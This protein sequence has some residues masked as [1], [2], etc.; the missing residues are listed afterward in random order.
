MRSI[1]MARSPPRV[2]KFGDF[3][4]STDPN[5]SHVYQCDGNYTASVEV[6]DDRGAV[7]SATVPVTVSSAGGP[8]T[9]A[10]DV[11]PVFNRVCTGCHGAARGLSLT[12]CENLQLGSNPRP[13][14]VVTP[15]VKEAS[16]LWQ[17]INS[18]TQP[19][20]PIGGLLPAAEIAA[21]GAWIDSL[22]PLDTNY[23]D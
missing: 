5:A 21:I 3:T 22:D 13:R 18:T 1:P 9:H 10:C 2:W 4:S 20:P 23:C 8:V 16:I 19:M 17:R 15:G 11:Q 6:V 14:P 7:A 12:T